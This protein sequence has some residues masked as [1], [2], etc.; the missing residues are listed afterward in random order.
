MN[1]IFIR[2]TKQNEIMSQGTQKKNNIRVIF[3][4]DTKRT[5]GFVVQI[6]I[7]SL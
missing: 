4:I 2:K 3:L 1:G 6:E 5:D 7:G